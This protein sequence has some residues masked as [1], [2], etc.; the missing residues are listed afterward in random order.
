MTLTVG[1]YHNILLDI[2]ECQKQPGGGLMSYG[3]E[4]INLYRRLGSIV[5]FFTADLPIERPTKFELVIN[6]KSA[7]ALGVTVR[8]TLVAM[9]N[10]FLL[11][12]RMSAAGVGPGAGQF[13]A[14][15]LTVCRVW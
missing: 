10:K 11:R 7:K 3:P 9:A 15:V 12:R 13:H 14:A 6:L 8:G 1:P 2:L 5:G 4:L